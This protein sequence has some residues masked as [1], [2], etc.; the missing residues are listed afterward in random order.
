MKILITGGAGF[1]GSHLCETLTAD[2]HELLIIDNFFTGRREHIPQEAACV[3][4]D[5]GRANVE[6]V[7]AIIEGFAPDAVVHLCAIHFI[8]YCMEN[9]GR[10]FAINTGATHTLVEALTRRSTRKLLFASTMDVY[11]ATDHTHRVGD[12]P[13]PSNV[14]GLTKSLSEDLIRYAT[15]VGAAESAVSFRLANV[16]GPRETNPHVIPDILKRFR[17]SDTAP[18]HM[19]YL[20]AMRDFIHVCDVVSAFRAALKRDTGTHSTFN[21]GTERPIAVRNVVEF[22]MRGA[23]LDR[24]IIEDKARFRRFDR[25]TLTPDCT[26]TREILGWRPQIQLEDGLR[27]LLEIEGYIK[28]PVT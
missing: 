17:E 24:P 11:E 25:A 5:L 1:I 3:E 6:D 8:P 20:G 26:S 22:L 27:R 14:Y 23:G 28:A 4:M 16:Y 13:R 7:H 10:T 2:G 21:L 15:T 19:G 9:P 12:Q 18:L